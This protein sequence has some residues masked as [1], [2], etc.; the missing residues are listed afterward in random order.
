MLYQ[1]YIHRLCKFHRWELKDKRSKEN[2]VAFSTTSLID[3]HSLH[4]PESNRETGDL[5]NSSMEYE[6]KQIVPIPSYCILRGCIKRLALKNIL[7]ITT[8]WKR[9]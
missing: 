5:P 4:H 7:L 3:T 8:Y 9:K 1:N 2:E 6:T